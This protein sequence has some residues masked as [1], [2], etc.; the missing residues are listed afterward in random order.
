MAETLY[1]DALKI[2]HQHWRQVPTTLSVH[3]RSIGM[4]NFENYIIIMNTYHAEI[5]KA[6]KYYREMLAAK[7]G[8]EDIDEKKL[9]REVSLHF[10]EIHYLWHVES[11]R[12]FWTTLVLEILISPKITPFLEELLKNSWYTPHASE[13]NEE[14]CVP[15]N[16]ED[17]IN[18][19]DIKEDTSMQKEKESEA[20]KDVAAPKSPKQDE[21][22]RRASI[23]E[24]KRL[25]VMP[26]GD[27]ERAKNQATL[28]Y[29]FTKHMIMAQKYYRQILGFNNPDLKEEE[30]NV[31]VKEDFEELS[32]N[33]AEELHAEAEKQKKKNA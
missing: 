12:E 22:Q 27:E 14:F 1:R 10:A 20:E 24:F 4:P 3:Q 32:K 23:S 16:K 31:Q 28:G 11:A 25:S 9:E 19:G 5:K 6:Q 26:E 8:S 30:I 13:Q 15:E 29:Q 18:K 17:I 2:A 7:V 21:K 33:M